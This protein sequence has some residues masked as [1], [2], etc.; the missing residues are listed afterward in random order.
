MKKSIQWQ[1]VTIIVGAISVSFAAF[2]L[3]MRYFMLDDYKQFM[4]T[5]DLQ[6]AQILSNQVGQTIA[7]PLR[8]QHM[9]ASYPS[10]MRLPPSEQASLILQFSLDEISYELFTV[11]NANG[12][13]TVQVV[14]DFDSAGIKQRL[15]GLNE[16]EN[17]S[18]AYRSPTT[19]DLIVTSVQKIEHDGKLE[20]TI[21]ADIS[22]RPL[23]TYINDFNHRSDLS[24]YL[25]DQNGVAIAQPSWFGEGLF[26]YETLKVI[27]QATD[28]AGNVLEDETDFRAP[29]G[30]V[31]AM[32]AAQRGGRGETTYRDQENNEYYCIY[33]P[34]PLPNS[35][36]NWALVLTHSA[37]TINVILNKLFLRALLGG[38]LISLL[39]LGV[40]IYFS[41][42]LTAP[43]R[44]IIEMANRIRAGDLSGQLKVKSDNEIGVLADNINYMI[45]GLRATRKKSQDAET[46]IKAIA[47]HDAL[48][49]LPN[50]THF[51]IYLRQ[52]MD[53]S[54]Q[55]RFY[56]ALLFIDVD[57]FKM[58]NDTY[59]H[60]VG[61]GLLI[62]FAKR[63]IEIAGRKE[64]ACRFGG[65]EFLLFLLGYDATDTRTICEKL[66]KSM[67]EPFEISGHKFSLSTSVGAALFPKDATNID[68]LLE[69]ADAALYVSKRNG[70]DQ[71]NFYVD[72]METTPIEDRD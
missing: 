62:A 16:Q 19:H 46:K 2:L 66:V 57:K 55:S 60:A 34:I 41:R 33:R 12:V 48:T 30:L 9:I 29:I 26:N 45:Q 1:L 61:D 67:R 17:V 36:K 63:I 52:M 4:Q 51:L 5:N 72:G 65:D 43:L 47:Y 68:D 58:V 71:Y 49:G 69:R 64:V 6:T 54:I 22:L 38:M 53:K 15:A 40:V 10:L 37:T 35:D 44:Q 24:A 3:I 42:E 50:R 14:G 56:G 59:G 21:V 25:F 20:G 7:R 23:Q 32:Q 13:S 70:R 31:R 11:L 8:R 28:N 27:K 39:T 18:A